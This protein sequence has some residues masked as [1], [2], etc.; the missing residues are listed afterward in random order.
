MLSPMSNGLGRESVDFSSVMVLSDCRVQNISCQNNLRIQ[1]RTIETSEITSYR[2]SSL[3]LK[4]LKSI[5][6]AA[7]VSSK[8]NRTLSNR[9]PAPFR[10]AFS[11]TSTLS[12]LQ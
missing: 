5:L 10:A 2:H 4:L 11:A 6:R 9:I 7:V 1:S 12:E 3:K 8:G